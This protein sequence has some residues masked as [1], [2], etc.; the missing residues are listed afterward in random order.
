MDIAY[1]KLTPHDL[2]AMWRINE[3]GLPGVGEI[4]Q[5]ALGDLLSLCELALGAY[6]EDALA[7]FVLCLLPGTRYGSPNYAW[8][9][10][11][12]EAFLYV[13]RIAVCETLRDRKI[14]SGLYEKVIAHAEQRRWPVAAEVNIHPP[15]PGSMRFHERHGF[16]KAGILE[17]GSKAVAMLL[18]PP[19]D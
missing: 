11:R 5:D 6:H 17:H 10:A 16:S 7:G 12:H 19:T 8:F 3:E 1:R 15:N 18:R 2:M 9:N 13:D 14:G 4:S